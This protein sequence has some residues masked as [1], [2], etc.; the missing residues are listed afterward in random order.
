MKADSWLAATAEEFL[1]SL[2]KTED[3]NKHLPSLEAPSVA[4]DW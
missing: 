3:I 2:L 4:G 1:I